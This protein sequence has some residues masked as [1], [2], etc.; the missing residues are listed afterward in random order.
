M[1]KFTAVFLAAVLLICTATGCGQ[2]GKKRIV[3]PEDE[4]LA[5]Y[6]SGN[7]EKMQVIT[8]SDGVMA[9]HFFRGSTQI[10]GEIY[11]PEGK[12]PFP[13]VLVSG[14]FAT[15]YYGYGGMA[16]WFAQNGIIGVVYDPS[17]MG[18][19]GAD[20]DD[21]L[22]WSPLTEVSDI[23][24]ILEAL[25]T[26]KIVDTDNIFLWGHSMGGFASAYVGFRNPDLI[27]GLILIEPALYLNDEAKEAF[28]D[29]SEIPDV[30]PGS[31]DFGR[32]YY[33]DLCSFDIYD[34]MPDYG[35]EVALFAGT[36]S[37]SIGT[38][39]PEYLTRAAE[40]LP[41]GNLIK[42]IGANHYFAGEPMSK[43]AAYTVYFVNE[44]SEGEQK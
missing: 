37:P 13:A 43:V 3:F 25:S 15:P 34:Y 39:E 11:V 22:N 4:L 41:S 19:M 1:K 17:D 28:P 38:D 44:L 9:V 26:L 16:E 30:V 29:I 42:V 40:L 21:F 31:P 23:E 33:R 14:G 36:V 2:T 18:N 10:Y 24:C 32:A 35:G 5:D 27:K 12:G 20:P 8:D 6:R 7:D